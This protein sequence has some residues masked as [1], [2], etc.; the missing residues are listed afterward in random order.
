MHVTP[1]GGT[2]GKCLTRLPLNTPLCITAAMPMAF[3]STLTLPTFV[4]CFFTFYQVYML[5]LGVSVRLGL[6]F[7]FYVY[8]IFTKPTAL[9]LC[10]TVMS[11]VAY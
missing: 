1:Q 8:L 2:G 7:I 9:S 5:P 11:Q 3:I 4:I 10:V 6:G